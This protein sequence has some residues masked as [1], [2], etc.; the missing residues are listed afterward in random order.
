MRK[1]DAWTDEEIS[2]LIELRSKR[3]KIKDICELL[4]RHTKSSIVEKLGTLNIRLEK[5]NFLGMKFGRWNVVGKSKDKYD[6]LVWDC[7]CDCQ[8]DKPEE[9]REHHYKLG[10][11]LKNGYSKSCGC[12]NHEMT[13]G[14]PSYNKKYNRYE[15]RDGYMVGYTSST[16]EEFYFDKEDYELI[17]NYCWNKNSTGYIVGSESTGRNV[18]MHRVIMTPDDLH[19]FDR[20]K[21]EVDHINGIRY[22]NRRSNLRIVNHYDNMK[23]K[24]IYSNNSSG[25]K[26]V[27]YIARDDLWSAYI[28]FN[29]K[30]YTEYYHSKEEAIEA[31][32]RMEEE[33]YG[34][35]ARAPENLLNR[36]GNVDTQIDSQ[37][38]RR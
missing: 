31:R 23:N 9:E 28:N 1:W 2:T 33:H 26:G 6:R 4:P 24:A 8:M 27:S 14:K 32:K 21:P 15:E 34:E 20:S 38:D 10:S 37:Y 11:V 17:K 3:T 19:R 18:Y 16:N 30:Q 12:R 22:D 7:V 29:D 35:F 13:K 36:N 5:D 25:C